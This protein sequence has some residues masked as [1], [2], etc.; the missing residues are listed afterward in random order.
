MFLKPVQA[1]IPK[2]LLVLN[3]AI[4]YSTQ[5]KLLQQFL[6]NDEVVTSALDKIFTSVFLSA[7]NDAYEIV[8]V[9]ANTVN[10]HSKFSFIR[11]GSPLVEVYTPGGTIMIVADEAYLEWSYEMMSNTLQDGVCIALKKE[12]RAQKVG[13]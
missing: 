4:P 2:G 6:N 9:L 7:A 12:I 11:A 5:K 3:D 8:L 10:T 1:Y 13:R